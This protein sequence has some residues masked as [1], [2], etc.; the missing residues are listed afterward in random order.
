MLFNLDF[1]N[2]TILSCSFLFFLT[3]DLYFLIPVVIAQTFNLIAELLI[4][5]GVPSKEA[6]VDTEI[7]PVTVEA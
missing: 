7:Q 1:S 2:N 4:P 5:M 6:K 3:T